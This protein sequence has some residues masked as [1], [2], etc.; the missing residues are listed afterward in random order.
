[1][2]TQAEQDEYLAEIR[3]QVCACCPGRPLTD[4]C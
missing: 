1:M 4:R 3:R 2:L